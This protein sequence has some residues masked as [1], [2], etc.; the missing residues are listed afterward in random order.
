MARHVDRKW[1]IPEAV[2]YQRAFLAGPEADRLFET[3]RDETAWEQHKVRIF[4]RHVK[5]PRL[6]AWHGDS[7]AVYAYSG[8]DYSPRPWTKELAEL[9]S[10]VG[11]TVGM[12]F[13]SVL[14][15]LYRSGA[16]SM[17]WHAD[18]EPEL[19][20]RPCIASVSLGA[21]RRFRLKP[22]T[23]GRAGEGGSRLPEGISADPVSIDL[24]HGSLLVMMG[25][26]QHRW[27]HALPK[28]SRDV[29]CRINLTFRRIVSV[30]T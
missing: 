1:I 26:C 30:E 28:T 22:R 23:V 27:R 21:E 11:E 3:L 18:D 15:N 9:R 7:G 12:E 16:D 25:A 5:C 6:S 8:F 2:L 29:G 14:L 24:E 10:R 20:D 13:N 17:G 19:G 4:G